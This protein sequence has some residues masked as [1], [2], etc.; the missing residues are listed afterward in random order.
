LFSAF[1]GPSAA[2]KNPLQFFEVHTSIQVYKCTHSKNLRVDLTHLREIE[3][4]SMRV[5]LT[6]MCVESTRMRVVRKNNNKLVPVDLRVS[7][8]YD[9]FKVVF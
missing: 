7:W 8:Y 5:D 4:K 2:V 6:R 9:E 3:N 1:A